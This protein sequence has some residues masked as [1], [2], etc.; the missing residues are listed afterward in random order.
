MCRRRYLEHEQLSFGPD[1]SNVARETDTSPS[2]V[3]ETAIE[4]VNRAPEIHL[5]V[6]RDARDLPFVMT[7]PLDTGES[8]C[9]RASME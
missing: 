8:C 7:N 5:R 2:G 1:L 6:V 3:V 4:E 9:K